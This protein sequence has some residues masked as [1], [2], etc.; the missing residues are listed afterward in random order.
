MDSLVIFL[1]PTSTPCCTSG[2]STSKTTASTKT[3]I[4]TGA[5]QGIDTNGLISGKAIALRLA[6]DGFDI[7]VN[8]VP[9]NAAAAESVS[10]EI[11][12][13]G[14]KSVTVIA[15]VVSRAEVE[16]MIQSSVKDLGPLTVMVA[17][18]GIVQVKPLLDSTEE[19]AQRVFDVNI[20]GVINCATLAAKQFIKQGGGGK[21]INAASG[22]SF[23]AAPMLG[24]YS[25]SKA[26]VRSLTHTFAMEFGMHKITVNA[27]APGVVGTKMWDKIDEE[28][29]K[30][31]G[32]QRGES[33]KGFEHQITLGRT[34]V[35]EDVVGTVSFLESQ[36]RTQ[37]ISRDKL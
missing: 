33:F 30:L 15:S 34:S 3:A 22:T 7:C 12:S 13:L 27:Y 21:I 4:I 35:P 18:A 25:A 31:K 24:F 20:H 23:R 28:M 29:A 1:P 17:N 11:R 36:A 16:S 14:R 32:V 2:P 9:S 6:Q 8:D 26:A 5:A 19:D 37:I 10:T